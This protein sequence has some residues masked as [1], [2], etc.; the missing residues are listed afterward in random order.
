MLPPHLQRRSLGQQVFRSM[1]LQHPS[2]KEESA[3]TEDGRKEAPAY[4]RPV[5][6]LPDPTIEFWRWYGDLH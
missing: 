4:Q 3:R 2:E 1:A 6:S 5:I